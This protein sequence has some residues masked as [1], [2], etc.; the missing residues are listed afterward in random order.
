MPFEVLP[1]ITELLMVTRLLFAEVDVVEHDQDVAGGRRDAD[2]GGGIGDGRIP[3]EQ[4]AAGGEGHVNAAGGNPG[5]GH[6]V[7]SQAF[8]RQVADAVEAGAGTVDRDV[9]QDHPVVDAG[10]DGDAV[11]ARREDAG[12]GAVAVD[13][14]GLGDGHGTKAAGIENGDL[15]AG[16]GL[17]DG[18]REGLAGS[19][20]AARVRVVTD[21]GNP[22]TG[23]LGVGGSRHEDGEG[24]EREDGTDQLH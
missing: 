10:V 14:D 16:R 13:G 17:R 23:G 12:Q 8:A 24:Q 21:T 2:A 15:A 1:E 18:A 4:V 20:T 11:G 6:L 3:H 19:R 9:A 5:D 7:Q 22:G